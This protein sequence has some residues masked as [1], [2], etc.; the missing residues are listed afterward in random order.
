[1]KA[2]KDVYFKLNLA[3]LKLDQQKE[4]AGN[5]IFSG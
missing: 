1:M 2:L 5:V 4:L 3:K